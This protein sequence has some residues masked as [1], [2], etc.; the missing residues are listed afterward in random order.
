MQIS[1]ELFQKILDQPNPVD[2][3]RLT[4]YCSDFTLDSFSQ[5]RKHFKNTRTANEYAYMFA[6]FFN[7][8]KK[9]ILQIS[10]EDVHYYFSSV[11]D[12]YSNHSLC[13]RIRALRAF[14][15]Y[16][17]A[18]ASNDTDDFDMVV[19]D[20]QREEPAEISDTGRFTGLFP[21]FSF[22]CEQPLVVGITMRDIDRVLS[23][24]MDEQNVTLFA[25]ISLVLR[26]GITTEEIC[27]LKIQ[28]LVTNGQADQCGIMILGIRNRFIK[29]PS[30]LFSLLLLLSEQTD[31]ETGNLFLTGL[32]RCPFTQ[33][34]LLLEIKKAC[35]RA[36]VRPFTLQQLRNFAILLMLRSHAPEEL[37]SDYVSTDSR[38]MSKYK[39]AAPSLNAAPCDY[40]A[41]SLRYNS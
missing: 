8:L 29:V 3:S 30:D 39:E 38:W 26:T 4:P 31:N 1:E 21:E 24:L 19:P 18:E 6:D 32:K 40:V 35:L 17:D 16:L 20:L 14:A 15:R 41:L 2:L 23:T 37:I 13:T 5:Y 7:L 36:E 11:R 10:A 9:D 12:K 22:E 27:G 34:N 28:Q 25:I 33:R